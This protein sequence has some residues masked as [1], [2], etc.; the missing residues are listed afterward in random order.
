MDYSLG[1]AKKQLT[2]EEAF[3]VLF[4]NVGLFDL[5]N[6]CFDK[7]GNYMYPTELTEDIHN[8]VIGTTDG[9]SIINSLLDINYY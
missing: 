1:Y 2:K 3:K 9:L 4:Q 5:R 7:Y 6:N 8:T